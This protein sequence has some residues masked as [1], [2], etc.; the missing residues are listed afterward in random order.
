VGLG[1]CGAMTREPVATLAVFP[2]FIARDEP[3]RPPDGVKGTSAGGVRPAAE[4]EDPVPRAL[5][6]DGGRLGSR[7]QR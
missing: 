3:C 1:W 6:P 7:D 5:T 4:V 2:E